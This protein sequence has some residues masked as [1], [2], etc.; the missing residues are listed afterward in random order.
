MEE[1]K[2]ATR[3]LAVMGV[4]LAMITALSALEH[5][6][7]PIA[8]LPPGVRLGLSN[9]VTMYALFFMGGRRAALL[10]VLKSL[11]VLLMRG[12]TSGF[13]SLCG[14]L[15]SII[16]IMLLAAISRGRLSYMI[17]SVAGAI[18]HNLGQV[19]A[20]SLLLKTNLVLLYIPVLTLFGIFMGSVTGAL[21]R[22]VMPLFERIFKK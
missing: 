18:F 19:L 3:G 20:A 22:I 6:L 13:L 10:T 8:F 16:V 2:T 21:L 9:I 17:L 12:V 7:P 5:T 1:I 14:G 15:L 11:F 4:M